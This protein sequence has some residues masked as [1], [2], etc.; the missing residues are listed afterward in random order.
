L[1]HLAFH[2]DDVEATLAAVLATGGSTLG[3]VVHR[4]YPELGTLAAVYARDPE[5]NILELQ[6]WER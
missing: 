3:E 4:E 1:G 2:V 6:N 5:G